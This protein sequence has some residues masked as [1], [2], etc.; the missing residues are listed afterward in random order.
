M[1]WPCLKYAIKSYIRT[2]ILNLYFNNSVDWFK[3]K[4]STE[5]CLGTGKLELI[6]AGD[7]VEDIYANP[8]K[9]FKRSTRKVSRWKVQQQSPLLGVDH[10]PHTERIRTPPG[11]QLSWK[12]DSPL[13]KVLQSQ[14]KPLLT[15]ALAH[16]I[17]ISM[18]DCRHR[19]ALQAG[20]QGVNWSVFILV[21]LG[22]LKFINTFQKQTESDQ[23][24]TNAAP[25]EGF[26]TLRL[27]SSVQQLS[28][29]I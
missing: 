17:N 13:H 23:R 18:L 3:L 12:A 9:I 1:F 27:F 8:R 26:P 7:G 14:S 28:K 11:A 15:A 4:I 20:D 22:A 21:P 10:I 25:R 16:L 5:S 29:I 6:C 2:S 24:L 19:L